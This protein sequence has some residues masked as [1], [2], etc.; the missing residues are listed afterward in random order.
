M[1]NLSSQ[2]RPQ[3]PDTFKPWLPWWDKQGKKKDKSNIL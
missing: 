3:T 2:P 1:P